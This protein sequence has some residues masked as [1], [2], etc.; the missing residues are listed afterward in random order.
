MNLTIY[1]LKDE[2][3]ELI[4]T[5]DIDFTLHVNENLVIHAMSTVKLFN[6]IT[7]KD[8]EMIL[9]F[10]SSTDLL[11]KGEKVDNKKYISMVPAIYSIISNHYND[12]VDFIHSVLIYNN[13]NISVYQLYTASIKEL[14]TILVCIFRLLGEQFG[15]TFKIK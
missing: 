10:I 13:Y 1:K 8:L 14:V 15:I 9:D 4:A 7:M 3:G 12:I 5:P 6:I 11:T 2:K